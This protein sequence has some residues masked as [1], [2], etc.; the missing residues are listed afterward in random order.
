MEFC[1][2]KTC[3]GRRS[4]KRVIDKVVKRVKFYIY[5]VDVRIN[6]SEHVMRIKFPNGYNENYG[7][8]KEIA[9]KLFNDDLEQFKNINKN[10]EEL[11]YL[12]ANPNLANN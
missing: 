5:Y 6:D 7:E 1:I 9:K 12:Q 11:L 3:I 10:S 4:Y 8:N 2:V